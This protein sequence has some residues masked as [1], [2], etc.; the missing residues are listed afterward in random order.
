[1]QKVISDCLVTDPLGD[2]APNYQ[3]D[4][5]RKYFV[6][7]SNLEI[8]ECFTASDEQNVRVP[9]HDFTED[10]RLSWRR[11]PV[12][13]RT[14]LE[15]L[16]IR[17]SMSAPVTLKFNDVESTLGLADKIFDVLIDEIELASYWAT[18]LCSPEF[19]KD[20]LQELTAAKLERR[21]IPVSMLPSNK[22]IV[23]PDPE[24]VGAMPL[25]DKQFGAFAVANHMINLSI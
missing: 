25:R 20:H 14:S 13:M 21:F 19:I 2:D 18:V 3:I 4:G 15:K 7:N 16:F 1:M 10:W 8:E 5:I 22:A 17:A 12:L 6:L 23:L 11:E 24:F 9:M